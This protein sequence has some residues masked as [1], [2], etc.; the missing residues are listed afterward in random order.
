M[1]DHEKA[2]RPSPGAVIVVPDAVPTMPVS[3]ESVNVMQLV[4]IAFD[5]NVI[6]FAK[7]PDDRPCG[8]EFQRAR[9]CS[10]TTRT[11]HGST[12][13]KVSIGW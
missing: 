11:R 6:A 2:R 12:W 9:M 1:H 8:V 13:G 5:V 10:F 4:V 3:A 7:P